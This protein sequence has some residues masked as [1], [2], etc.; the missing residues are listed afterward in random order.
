GNEARLGQ[1]FLNLIVNAAQSMPTTDVERNELEVTTR[2]DNE[3]I[4]VEIRDN[5]SGIPPH[6]L[7]R[8]F[9]PFFTTKPVGKGTGLGLAICYRIVTE[10]GG[11]IHVES[12][13]GRGTTIRTQLPIFDAVDSPPSTHPDHATGP[14]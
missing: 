2:L 5:G 4:V 10:L 7:P 3:R 9:D 8:I 14:A 13:V 6:I 1:V 11:D 12:N